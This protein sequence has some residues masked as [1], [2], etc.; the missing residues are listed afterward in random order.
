MEK[1]INV[2]T[3]Q[4]KKAYSVFLWKLGYIDSHAFFVKNER[5][6]YFMSLDN[7]LKNISVKTLRPED[8]LEGIIIDGKQV[9]FTDISSEMQEKIRRVLHELESESASPKQL[10]EKCKACGEIGFEISDILIKN[11]L[12]ELATV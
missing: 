4:Q 3:E 2:L 10:E 9:F 5:P 12:A 8:W 11:K 7:I 6:G 1:I